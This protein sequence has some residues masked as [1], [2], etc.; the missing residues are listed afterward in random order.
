MRST[1]Q[2]TD[3]KEGQLLPPLA[4]L[5]TPSL[6][7]AGAIASGDYENVHHD[8][9]AAQ[10]AGT[11][12]IFMN[13][14]TSNGWVQR[15]VTDWAG[16]SARIQSIEMRLGAPN[17]PNE[18]MTLTGTVIRKETVEGECRIELRISGMNSLG[19]HVGATV[20]LGLPVQE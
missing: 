14:L 7:V 4:V 1:L 3:V 13:I 6:I 17:F 18:T 9:A 12:D 19:E 15:Y 10:K 5:I 16:P 20:R 8:F 2:A 11:R